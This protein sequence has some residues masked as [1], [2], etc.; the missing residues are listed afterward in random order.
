MSS[1]P[2]PARHAKL[3]SQLLLEDV[4]LR[5]VVEEFVAS[6]EL[7]AGELR[8]AHARLDWDLLAAL[9]HRLKGAAGSYGYPS[10]SR[11]CA[12]LEQRFRAH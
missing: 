3:L 1:A 11:L 8:Q 12:E 6:L 9:A 2:E 7:R 5:D 4:N 10:I